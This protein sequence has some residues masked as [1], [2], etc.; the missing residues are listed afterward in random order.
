MGKI[1]EPVDKV[2]NGIHYNYYIGSNDCLIH[3][4]GTD[5][6]YVDAYD[7]K[8]A[9]WK[10]EETDEPINPPENEVTTNAD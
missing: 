6:L 10:Y 1:V 5:E 7:V 8:T 2:L 9:T 3:K 4:I